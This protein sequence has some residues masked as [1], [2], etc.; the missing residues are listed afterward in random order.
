MAASGSIAI[1]VEPEDTSSSIF[2]GNHDGLE[3]FITDDYPSNTLFQS[4]STLVKEEAQDTMVSPLRGNQANGDEFINDD[5]QGHSGSNTAR[6]STQKRRKMLCPNTNPRKPCYSRRKSSK[7]HCRLLRKKRRLKA[8]ATIGDSQADTLQLS[9]GALEESLFTRDLSMARDCTEV[10]GSEHRPLETPPGATT[11]RSAVTYIKEEP[12]DARHF[13]SHG[14]SG[15]AEVVAETVMVPS[16]FFCVKEEPSS[17]LPGNDEDIDELLMSDQTVINT[18]TF[19]GRARAP[20]KYIPGDGAD[21][22]DNDL[23]D[24]ADE[25]ENP[26]TWDTNHS[27]PVSLSDTESEDNPFPALSN[28]KKKKKPA[29]S[30]WVK[31]ALQVDPDSIKFCGDLK[32]PAEILELQTPLEFFKFFMTN[33]IICHV[34]RESN[35]Y[36]VQ[37]RPNKPTMISE[38]EVEQ[39]FGT[40]LFMSVVQLPS[41]RL[42]WSTS[43]RQPSIAEALS[44]NRWEEIKRFLHFNNNS[45]FVASGLPGHDKL[46]KIRPLLTMLNDR[47]HLVPKEEHLAVG[48]QIIPA[49]TRS[50][51]KQYNPKKPCKWGYK[52]FVLCGVSGF[53]YEIEIFAGAQTNAVPSGFPNLG[54][55][56]NVVTRLCRT[57]PNHRNYKL[58]FNNCFN[59]LPL[60]IYLTKAGL[61]PLGTVAIDRVPGCTMPKQSDMKKFGR[62]AMTEKTTV[63]DGV[64]VSVVTWYDNRVVRTMSTYIGAKPVCEAERYDRKGKQKLKIP[65][66]QSVKIYNMYMGGLDLLD[67]TL[68][69]CRINIKSKK[70][71]HKIAFHILDLAAVNAWLLYRR[72]TGHQ[73]A[74]IDFKLSVAEGL[75]KVGKRM[76]KRKRGCPSNEVESQLEE[77]KRRG[78]A[79]PVPQQDV[80]LDGVCHF[81]VFLNKRQR[82]KHP[83]CTGKSLVLCEKCQVALCLNKERN[84]F[85]QFHYR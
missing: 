80:R 40:A 39:F 71:Y 16:D 14:T 8:H 56:S 66:P 67:S 50:T 6:D 26:H 34:T 3:E 1:K 28:L 63:V 77:K 44:C 68:G 79:A 61:P 18:Q 12:H 53:C 41:R 31:R 15:N 69:Y 25:T 48:E 7:A 72:A 33:E 47:L 45:T 23:S 46:H 10:E 49:R 62:G 22:T 52:A 65:C 11:V 82:C 57:V 74:L 78:R 36:S 4:E 24:D 76:Q 83:Q 38:D 21:S 35:L 73:M 54:L 37:N 75:C 51:L 20:T 85:V 30:K 13:P 42:Y 5:N 59:S 27:S 64:E 32:L 19:C 84:C 70:W 58:F 43:L 17:P 81:P 2:P 55:S 9:D 60:Q 29:Q